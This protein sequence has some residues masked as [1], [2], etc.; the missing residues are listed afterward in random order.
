MQGQAAIAKKASELEP[1]TLRHQV[2]LTAQKFKSS[3]VELGAL[4]VRYAL[5][6]DVMV[7][8]GVVMLLVVLVLLI[9]ALTEVAYVFIDPRLRTEDER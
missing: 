9:N 6:K 7:I 4:L 3:W 1:G 5:N 2:L 8:E